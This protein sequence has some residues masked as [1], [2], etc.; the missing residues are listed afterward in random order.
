MADADRRESA[1]PQGDAGKTGRKLLDRHPWIIYVLPLA[2]FMLAGDIRTQKERPAEPSFW[3]LPYAAYPLV[4]TLKIA[5]TTAAIGLVWPGYRQFGRRLS[6]WGPGGRPGGGGALD[7]TVQ[8][9]PGA[10]AA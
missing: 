3:D 5:L 2:M 1:Q 6:A 10:P 8:A 7:R 9:G 4:Y